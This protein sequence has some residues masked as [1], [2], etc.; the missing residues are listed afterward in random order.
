MAIQQR[1]Q[2]L[3]NIQIRFSFAFRS[4]NNEIIDDQSQLIILFNYFFD[5]RQKILYDVPFSELS[6]IQIQF[7]FAF[8]SIIDEI[9]GDQST[10]NIFV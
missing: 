4:I 7:S 9:I 8:W 5:S 10:T 1:T 6:N 2:E 3:S